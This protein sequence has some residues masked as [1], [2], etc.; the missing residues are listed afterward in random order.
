MKYSTIGPHLSVAVIGAN[1]IEKGEMETEWAVMF[2]DVFWA[3]NS[4]GKN[5]C[6]LQLQRGSSFLSLITDRRCSPYR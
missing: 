5:A 6:P 3:R 1:C 4:R 2:D